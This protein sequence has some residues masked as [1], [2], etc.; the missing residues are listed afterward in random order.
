MEYTPTSG[1]ANINNAYSFLRNTINFQAS[2]I[3]NY[4]FSKVIESLSQD[5]PLYMRGANNE[6]I[7]HAWVVDGAK[8]YRTTFC[9]MLYEA[10]VDRPSYSPIIESQWRLVSTDVY[11]TDVNYV[12]CNFGHGYSVLCNNGVFQSYNT[13]LRIIPNIHP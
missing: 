5:W 2:P 8:I 7:G 13:G 3:E 4:S 12:N 1:S 10:T 9:D 6:G 11:H